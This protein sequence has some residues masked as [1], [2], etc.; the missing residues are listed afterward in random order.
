[1]TRLFLTELL[2]RLD[3][4]NVELAPTEEA[5]RAKYLQALRAADKLDWQPLI[6][7]WATRLAAAT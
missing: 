2:R 1:M 3:L 5:S 6:A 7:L 4:P